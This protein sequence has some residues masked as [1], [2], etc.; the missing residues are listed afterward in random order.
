M[1]KKTI[2]ALIACI[3]GIVMLAALAFFV[4]SMQG[5]M[6]SLFPALRPDGAADLKESEQFS[7]FVFQTEDEAPSLPTAQP[8]SP[9]AV[10]PEIEDASAVPAETEAEPEPGK[11]PAQHRILFVGDSRTL[12]MRDALKRS[13]RADEDVFVGKVG[14]GVRWFREEGMQEMADAIRENPDLPVVLNLGVNDPK[15]TDDYIVTYWDCVREH[16]DTKFY[17]LS[18]NP[19]D[20]EFLIDSETAAEEV[21]D[22]I[23]SLNIAKLNLRLKEEFSDR[24]LD[25]SSFLRQDGFE[26]VDG[27]HYSTDTYLKIHDFV[28][29]QLF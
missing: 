10:S 18:V 25:S 27:L 12:G 24:Y 7:G 23:N 3:L 21:L 22:T 16:P 14:E 1:Q 5:G 8:G 2:A 29:S 28:V 9:E 19:I 15:E 20:E 17:I 4:L 26:T 11:L 13:G 6:S